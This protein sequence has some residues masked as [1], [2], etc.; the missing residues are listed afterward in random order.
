MPIQKGVPEMADVP[1]GFVQVGD[2]ACGCPRY[3]TGAGIIKI[4]GKG[5]ADAVKPK[6]TKK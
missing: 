6:A 3:D 4:H 5:C 2:A 1:E